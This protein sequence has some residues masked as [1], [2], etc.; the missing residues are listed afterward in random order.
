MKK[1]L[2]WYSAAI[3]IVI[4]FGTIYIVAQQS[5][6]HDANYPQTQIAE[7]T[8]SELNHGVDPSKLVSGKVDMAASLAPFVII[9]DQFGKPLV[10]SGYLNG[11]LPKMPLDS[12]VAASGQPYSFVT[13]QPANNVRI[14]A[15]TVAANKYFVTS[16][17]SLT[18]VEKN[19]TNSLQLSAL[20]GLS[21]ILVILIL[22]GL[23]EQKYATNNLKTLKK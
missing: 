1:L 4:I 6:R 19:E 12:L 8:A 15:V 23:T 16:G 7:D 5:Q 17:R 14:A 10:G 21:A 11:K 20:G 18:E 3:I 22:Y 2:P 13:W 9:Y